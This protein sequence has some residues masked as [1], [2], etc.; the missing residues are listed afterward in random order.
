M[1]VV[2]WLLS[3]LLYNSLPDP[4]PTHWSFHGVA[5]GFTP[6]PWGAF[7]MPIVITLLWGL[8]AAA[9]LW[10]RRLGIEPFARVFAIYQAAILGFF[11]IIAGLAFVPTAGRRIQYAT[12]A[13]GILLAV[14]GNYMQS[15]N[16]C[17]GR[18]SNALDARQSRSLVTD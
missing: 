9:F 10:R 4:V 3:L 6:K 8:G 12:T 17:L 16:Q 18:S 14:L 2:S 13:L 1:V 7:I 5:D 15:H 11:F